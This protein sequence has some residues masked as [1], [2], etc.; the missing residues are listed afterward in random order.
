MPDPGAGQPTQT[1]PP[2]DGSFVLIRPILASDKPL[3][4]AGFERL[5]KDSRY[6]RFLIPFRS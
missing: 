1:V 4:R 6:R 3:I 2:R 5:S